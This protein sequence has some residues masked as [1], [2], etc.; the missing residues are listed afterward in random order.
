MLYESGYAA[1][2]D[3]AEAADWAE[4]Y[5]SGH[6]TEG[7]ELQGGDTF[8]GDWQGDTSNLQPTPDAPTQARACAH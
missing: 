2:D 5:Y 8:E 7:G 1:A 3:E 6:G 4:Y